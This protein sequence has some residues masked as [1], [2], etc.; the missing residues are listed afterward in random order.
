MLSFLTDFEQLK[1]GQF[2]QFSHLTHNK[3]RVRQ[4]KSVKFV[5]AAVALGTI[6]KNHRNL[7]WTFE[8]K[9]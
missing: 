7:E 5:F 9:A 3:Y 4:K 1:S 6:T 2:G 8:E